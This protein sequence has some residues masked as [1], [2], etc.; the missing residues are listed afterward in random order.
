MR[1]QSP[2]RQ[3]K[4]AECGLSPSFITHES[5]CVLQ[6]CLGLFCVV[7][8]ST[9]LL[10]HYGNQG[11]VAL[12]GAPLYCCALGTEFLSW[13]CQGWIYLYV[14]Q[15]QGMSLISAFSVVFNQRTMNCEQSVTQRWESCP[16][17]CAHSFPSPWSASSTLPT[18]S[19][20][21]HST[22]WDGNLGTRQ[23]LGLKV[24]VHNF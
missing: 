21:A 6:R 1:K 23:L 18:L 22:H 2:V 11:Q 5:H 12:H 14:T 24:S 15:W 20:K 8:H 9:F 4:E 19:W 16:S 3:R 7:W 10:F 13:P 17:F